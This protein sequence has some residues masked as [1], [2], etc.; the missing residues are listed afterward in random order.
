MTGQFE[1]SDVGFIARIVVGNDD[2]RNMLTEEEIRQQMEQVNRC[3]SETPRGHIIGMERGGVSHTIG[4]Q[5]VVLQ[6]CVYHIGFARKPLFMDELAHPA[7]AGVAPAAH[8]SVVQSPAVSQPTAQP[9]KPTE[10]VRQPTTANEATMQRVHDT[11][12][13]I[14]VNGITLD[15]LKTILTG[16]DSDAR[17]RQ[18]LEPLN[19]AMQAGDVNS[20]VR[21]SAFLAQVLAESN[22]LRHVEESLNYRPD[23]LRHVWPRYFPDERTAAAYGH[24]PQ[25]LANRV[26]AD[27]LGNG[28]EASG[29]GWR[30]RGRG[31]IEI[32]GRANYSAFSRTAGLD[33]L[34]QP[35]LLSA[36]EGAAR[37]AAWFWREHGLNQLAD[38]TAGPDGFR[39][40]DEIS[41]RVNGGSSGLDERRAYWRR[42]RLALGIG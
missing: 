31:L 41:R 29:D 3:L 26:Y 34:A 22:E 2:P 42:T 40:F 23:R 24:N 14:T 32:T 12:A 16:D 38:D 10:P 25:A 28:D 11:D 13:E 17:A 1:M 39:P 27:R 19:A 35:D 21:R 5:Q 36:P 15:Q 7:R 6:Y 9:A 33:A 30:Y 20:P 8:A 4:E 18:W 37:A